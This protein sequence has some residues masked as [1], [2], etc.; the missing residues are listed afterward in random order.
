MVEDVLDEVV[1]RRRFFLVDAEGL[2]RVGDPQLSSAQRKFAQT[3]AVTGRWSEGEKSSGWTLREVV[4]RA[5]P[6]ILIG[7]ST[8]GGLFDEGV[9]RAMARHVER[10]IIFPLSNPTSCAEGLPEQILEWT[11]GSALVATGAPFGPVE[12]RGRSVPVAQVNNFY[13]FPGVGQGV[14]AVKARRVTNAMLFDAARALGRCSPAIGHKD[15]ALL[16]AVEDM[17]EAAI[18]IAVAVASRAVADGL[19]PSPGARDLEAL[20]RR[21][22]WR[23]RYPEIIAE[24]GC[25]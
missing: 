13:I 9:V 16:P 18:P 3:A 8:Q 20:I 1:A 14:A 21:R 22:Y 24:D 6:T 17:Q 25:S 10:P 15:A 23:P 7:V 4:E 2:V 12:C 19:A 5:Q 11:A